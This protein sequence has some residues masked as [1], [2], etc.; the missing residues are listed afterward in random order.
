MF[1][2]VPVK[3]GELFKAFVFDVELVS[4][5]IST[6]NGVFCL[7]HL[8]VSLSEIQIKREEELTRNPLSKVQ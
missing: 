3:S 8:Y 6:R 2:I 1:V 5:S 4:K 7:Q